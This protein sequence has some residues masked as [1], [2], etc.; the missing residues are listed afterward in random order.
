MTIEKRVDRLGC[1][2]RRKQHRDEI[3]SREGKRKESLTDRGTIMEERDNS[4]T[5]VTAISHE[6]NQT[7]SKQ[8][9]SKR[10]GKQIRRGIKR[11]QGLEEI[12][13]AHQQSM[14]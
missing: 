3:G 2:R 1:S 8:E 7:R 14:R 6:E 13:R 10:D 9:N 5:A 4:S 12:P 11:G